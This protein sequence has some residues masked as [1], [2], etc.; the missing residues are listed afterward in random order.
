MS[1]E[2]ISMEE[3]KSG[4]VT[5][6]EMEEIKKVWEWGATYSEYLINECDSST[7][8]MA[9]LENLAEDLMIVTTNEHGDRF[10]ESAKEKYKQD[11]RDS[12]EDGFE[13]FENPHICPQCSSEQETE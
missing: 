3:F 13:R 9:L 4:Y 7:Q 12:L 8:M 6:S 5:S 1:A 2:V 11:L 10:T